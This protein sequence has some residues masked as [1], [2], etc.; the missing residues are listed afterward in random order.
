MDDRLQFDKMQGIGNDFVVVDARARPVREWSGLA[1]A[2]C[3]RRF[4]AGADGLLIVDSDVSA[5][6]RMRM[7]NPDGTADFCGNGLRCVARLLYDRAGGAAGVLRI[8][9][10]TG[11]RT[12]AVTELRH[13]VRVQVAMAAPS[14]A[15]ADIPMIASGDRVLDFR[16]PLTEGDLRITAL[17]TGSTHAVAFVDRLPGDGDFRRVSPQVEHH[18]L[19]PERTSLMWARVESPGRIA[20]RIWERGV[21]ET[22]GCGTGACA[23]MVAARLHGYVGDAA[24]VAS[25]GG[26]LEVQWDEGRDLLQAGPA[27]YVYRGRFRL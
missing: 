24:T 13:G 9:T 21:G 15:P 25:G 6:A 5:D 19:F 8:A 27:E 26:E 18:P 7:Y 20:L 23:A 11:V 17:S 1:I 22:L 2:M 14:F 4:G 10:S 12:A 3:D 16:L